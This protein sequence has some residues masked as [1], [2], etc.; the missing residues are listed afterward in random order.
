VHTLARGCEDSEG[1]VAE[2]VGLFQYQKGDPGYQATSL[3]VL[4]AALSL[5]QVWGSLHTHEPLAWQPPPSRLGKS[6][7][8]VLLLARASSN[9]FSFT[10]LTH[11][12]PPP[13]PT[14]SL[15]TRTD[16]QRCGCGGGRTHAGVRHGLDHGAE[17]ACV[18][19]PGGCGDT[20]A[21]VPRAH[22]A[23]VAGCAAVGAD[24][25]MIIISATRNA[26][27]SKGCGRMSPVTSIILAWCWNF[28][29]CDCK[30]C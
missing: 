25:V 28:W 19:L 3:M 6:R 11:R 8:Q 2:T 1:K 7:Q 12:S 13:P 15:Y 5:L 14:P 4:E 9:A 20:A 22:A 29:T 21:Q 10:P 26:S 18:G 16:T 30:P 27:P 17:P 23:V 24:V